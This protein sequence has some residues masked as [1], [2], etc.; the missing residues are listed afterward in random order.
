MLEFDVDYES[1]R[2]FFFWLKKRG[3]GMLE[4]KMI[5]LFHEFYQGRLFF[6]WTI[7]IEL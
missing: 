7:D 5:E 4:L 6:K 2:K 3:L 1:I